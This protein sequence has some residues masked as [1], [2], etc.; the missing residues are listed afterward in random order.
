VFLPDSDVLVAGGMCS[1][2][3]MPLIDTSN[4]DVGLAE[5]PRAYQAALSRLAAPPGVPRSRPAA[6][7]TA[8]LMSP[9][10]ARH[11]FGLP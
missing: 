7:M 11:R 3:E 8:T 6:G 5:Q 1:G 2:I 4:A 10:A 9:A